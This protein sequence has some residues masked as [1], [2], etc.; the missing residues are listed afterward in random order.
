M[1]TVKA[2][3]K[4]DRREFTNDSKRDDKWYRVLRTNY[5]RYEENNKESWEDGVPQEVRYEPGD[6]VHGLS[7]KELSA[8]G[9]NFEECLP[10]V[11]LE[12]LKDK[13]KSELQDLAKE[14]NLPPAEWKDLNKGPLAEYLHG[15]V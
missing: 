13:K 4:E 15:E 6:K 2:E 10:P 11:S 7:D 9:D 5:S 8:F 3:A 12:D 14:A 1:A